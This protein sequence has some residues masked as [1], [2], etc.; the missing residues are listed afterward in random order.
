MPREG[1]GIG[2]AVTDGDNWVVMGGA[3]GVM[4]ERKEEETVVGGGGVG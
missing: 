3:R 1:V 4:E 2:A